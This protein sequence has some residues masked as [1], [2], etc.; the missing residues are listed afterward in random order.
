MTPKIV[1]VGSSNT[2]MVVR[3]PRIPAPGETILGEDL[4]MVSGGKG[5]NQAVAAARLGAE[6]VFVARVGTDL[7][8]ERAIREIAS[9]GVNTEYIVRDDA[10]PSGVALIC[11]AENGQNAIVVAPGTNARLMPEDVDAAIAAIRES[12]ILVLQFETPLDTVSH[13]IAIAKREGK[14]VIL[15]PAPAQ[16][17]P[18][19]FLTGVDVLTPMRSRRR[20]FSTCLR[21]RSWTPKPLDTLCSISELGRW[22]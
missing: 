22:Y 2:D 18:A 7:F 8:G 12:D 14:R 9:A 1:V 10:A 3:T 6:V 15:N 17:L 20:C 11:V 19:G 5:A 4:V 13:A 21:P 16:L